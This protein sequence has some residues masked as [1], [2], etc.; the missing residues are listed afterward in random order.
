LEYILHDCVETSASQNLYITRIRFYSGD[1]VI[2]ATSD[3]HLGYY[4]SDQ[5][6]FK[7]FLDDI[8]DKEDVEYFVLVGDILDMWRR[9]NLEL[10]F[11]YEDVLNKLKELQDKKREVHYVVGNHDYHLIELKHDFKKKYN[12]DLCMDITLPYGDQEFYFIHGYQ[13]EFPHMLDVYQDFANVLCLSDDTIGSDA[14]QLWELYRAMSPFWKRL[15][16]KVIDIRKALK[17]P[18]NRLSDRDIDKLR[19]TIKEWRTKYKDQ[20]DDKFI[21]YGH[22]HRPFVDIAKREA[23][24]G[25]WVDDPSHPMYEKNTYIIIEKD[26]TVTVKEY[27]P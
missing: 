13:F 26:G 8:V 18:W 12:L 17:P 9:D 4:C 27:S 11:E 3:V 22:T 10:L 6:L 23:N 16:A 21:V 15:G 14:D 24:T 20:I 2:I 7:K 5:S 1:N 19:K 25:S